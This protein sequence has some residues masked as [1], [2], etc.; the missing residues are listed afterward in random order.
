MGIEEI[1]HKI[2][3]HNRNSFYR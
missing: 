1:V 2:N 3:I